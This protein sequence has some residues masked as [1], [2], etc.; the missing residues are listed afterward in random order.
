VESG[1]FGAN[2]AAQRSWSSQEGLQEAAR[3]AIQEEKEARWQMK[4]MISGMEE[5]ELASMFEKFIVS[6]EKE[7][8]RSL[9]NILTGKQILLLSAM[10]GKAQARVDRRILEER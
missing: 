1:R 7:Q 6:I 10:L 2:E 5:I 8:M 4:V 9:M 3:Q